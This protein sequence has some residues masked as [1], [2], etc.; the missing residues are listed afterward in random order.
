M[1]RAEGGGRTMSR[2]LGM[3]FAEGGAPTMSRALGMIFMGAF[4]GLLISRLSD[5]NG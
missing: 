3:I 1:G 2:T 4:F 5:R